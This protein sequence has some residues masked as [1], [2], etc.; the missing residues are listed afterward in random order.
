MQ[1]HTHIHIKNIQIFLT[2]NFCFL[3]FN[4]FN[5]YYNNVKLL[6][7]FHIFFNYNILI[8]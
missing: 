1:T 6:I 7:I 3:I 8:K 5:V 4:S 2:I